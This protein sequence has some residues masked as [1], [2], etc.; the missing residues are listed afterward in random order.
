M[1]AESVA[2][3]QELRAILAARA[4]SLSNPLVVEDES[5]TCC[6]VLEFTLAYER[7]GVESQS[8]REVHP[9]RELTPVPCTPPFVLGIVNIRGRIV[10][11]IDLRRFFDLPLRGLTDLNQVIILA[12][13]DVE[14]GI[15]ADTIVGVRQIP[16]A[17]IQRSLPTLTGVRAKFL[18][19]VTGERM[20]I[21]DAEKILSDPSL[22]VHQEVEL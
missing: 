16:E 1:N 9:L 5:S 3:P 2:S 12:H 22:V 7:Y 10:S 6:D 11:V 17:F 20:A 19:G 18:R 8:V 13:A 15:L 14:L 4:V 21:L